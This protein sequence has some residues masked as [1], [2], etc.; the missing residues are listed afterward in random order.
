M[1]VGPSSLPFVVH[2]PVVVASSCVWPPRARAAA[3]LQIPLAKA[4][5]T[6]ARAAPTQMVSLLADGPLLLTRQHGVRRPMGVAR[7]PPVVSDVA[8]PDPQGAAILNPA[9]GVIGART[10]VREVDRATT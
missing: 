7:L 2:L 10:S 6:G 8:P 4:T 3:G 1:C 5:L 9:A